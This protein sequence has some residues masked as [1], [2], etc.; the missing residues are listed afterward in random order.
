MPIYFSSKSLTLPPFPCTLSPNTYP[1]PP[2][3]PPCDSLQNED[4][5]IFKEEVTVS[6]HQNVAHSSNI[7]FKF[8]ASFSFSFQAGPPPP[9]P[10]PPKRQNNCGRRCRQDHHACSQSSS[11]HSHLHLPPPLVS[12]GC[13]AADKMATPSVQL[14]EA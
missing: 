7:I 9:P 4:F 10:P 5:V 12:T 13:K 14:S 2:P 1:P 11:H 3:P 6:V 8:N